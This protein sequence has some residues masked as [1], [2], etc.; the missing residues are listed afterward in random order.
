M[1][2]TTPTNVL[3]TLEKLRIFSEYPLSL[4]GIYDGETPVQDEMEGIDFVNQQVIAERTGYSPDLIKL[5]GRNPLKITDEEATELAVKFMGERHRP[6]IK[7]VD[8]RMFVTSLTDNETEFSPGEY[9]LIINYLKGIGCITPPLFEKNHWA[10]N[11]TLFELEL[12]I[13]Q[14]IL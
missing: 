1:E 8:G 9:A 10:Y 11:K 4:I 3:T 2:T 7:P 14:S 5:I 13:E 12:A 6:L